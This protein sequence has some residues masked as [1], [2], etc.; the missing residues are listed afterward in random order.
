MIEMAPE[1]A[2]RCKEKREGRAGGPAERFS[3]TQE[4]ARL[5]DELEV[6]FGA[7]QREA[8]AARERPLSL[9]KLIG[10]QTGLRSSI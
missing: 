4:N 6:A 1:T 3:L 7:L 10:A 9:E 2:K 8:A 5:R